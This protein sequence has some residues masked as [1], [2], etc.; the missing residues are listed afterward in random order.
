MFDYVLGNSDRLFA[1]K[2]Y[3]EAYNESKSLDAYYPNDSKIQ[4][5]QDAYLQALYEENRSQANRH[6]SSKKYDEAINILTL[7]KKYFPDD[8]ELTKQLTEAEALKKKAIE[9]EKLRKEKRTKEL[10]AQ[11]ISKFDDMTGLTTIVPKGYSATYVNIS[12]RINIEPRIWILKGSAA[13]TVI[14]GFQQ[15]DWVFTDEIIFNVD[16]ELFT[17]E[18]EYG[19]RQTQVQ[20][21]GIAEWVTKH[22]FDGTD[23][24]NQM[25]K[26]A[27]GKTVKMRFGGSEGHSDHVVTESEKANM[28]L[29]LELYT[30]YENL[31]NAL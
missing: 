18:L 8:A 28:K 31:D 19:D 26:V 17:W 15:D 13:F 20:Y 6:V 7:T 9:E 1:E 21:G 22:S 27:N 10:L 4:T 2:K 23:L 12:G 5:K 24:V 29:I 14:A 30:Y 11:V 3:E 25:E 16:G